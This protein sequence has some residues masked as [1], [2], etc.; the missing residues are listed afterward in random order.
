M[1]DTMG[2]AETPAG[3]PVETPAG[4]TRRQR[5]LMWVAITVT[6]GIVGTIAFLALA[7]AAFG[8]GAAGGCGGG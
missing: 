4:M 6:L 1:I 5:L 8:S 7:T 2:T 3:M